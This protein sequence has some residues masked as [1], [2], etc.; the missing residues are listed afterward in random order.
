MGQE[1][2]R[3]CDE[4]GFD[5]YHEPYYW[6]PRK[7]NNH[8]SG[9]VCK[10]KLAYWLKSPKYILLVF[11]SFSKNQKDE[12][13]C[14]RSMSISIA[15]FLGTVDHGDD[16]DADNRVDWLVFERVTLSMQTFTTDEQT[17]LVVNDRFFDLSISR[18]SLLDVR[19]P[20]TYPGG[21]LREL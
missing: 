12:L 20:G 4:Y 6:W 21:A 15:R 3:Y 14:Y 2:K 8:F 10:W 9:A 19:V 17:E 1:V 13:T 18:S 11:F 5:F 16:A 7:E